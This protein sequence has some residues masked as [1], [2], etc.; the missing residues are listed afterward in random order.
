MASNS[1]YHYRYCGFCGVSFQL[2]GFLEGWEVWMG[3]CLHS[4]Q[5]R[6]LVLSAN[7]CKPEV[8]VNLVSRKGGKADS[9]ASCKC[10]WWLNQVWFWQ[11]ENLAYLLQS[12]DCQ[13]SS[14]WPVYL[15]FFTAWFTT[16]SRTVNGSSCEQTWQLHLWTWIQLPGHPE[17]SKV[18]F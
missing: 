16:L 5:K 17:V 13:F 9:F 18:S 3:G 14:V 2:P 6:I 8:L 11:G 15:L 7:T 12:W 4:L 10:G 1:K